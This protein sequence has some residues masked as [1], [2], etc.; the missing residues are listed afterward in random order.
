MGFDC[1]CVYSL[2]D[3]VKWAWER[4]EP[5]Q[6][7]EPNHTS[8]KA[9]TTQRRPAGNEKIII[10]IEFKIRFFTNGND[11]IANDHTDNYLK[12]YPGILDFSYLTYLKS[13]RSGRKKTLLI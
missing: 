6:R 12:V 8:Y 13:N 10:K 7:P 11:D 2:R 4:T 1:N 3:G 5:G 9:G